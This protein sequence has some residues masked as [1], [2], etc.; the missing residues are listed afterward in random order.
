MKR[1]SVFNKREQEQ[2]ELF[3][4]YLIV[5]RLL[6]KICNLGTL[7]DNLVRDNNTKK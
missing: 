3:D 6:A 7:K 1:L 4:F 2:G 5:L